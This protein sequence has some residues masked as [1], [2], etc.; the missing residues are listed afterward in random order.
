MTLH[1][2]YGS[3]MSR[4][5]MEPR[6]PGVTA[7]GTAVLHGFGFIIGRGGYASLEPRP[8]SVV[9]GVLW[10]LSARD[11]AAIDAYEGG[12]YLRRTLPVRRAGNLIPALVYI[13]ARP[14]R[15]KPRPA[16]IRL[17][18]EAAREWNLPQAYVGSLERWSPASL[19]GA[20]AKEAGEIG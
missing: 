3:N 16:Y 13:M 8:G 12:L 7:L 9:H 6:C 1:F 11:L 14:G 17:V 5:L 19:A 10:R 4:A 20:R 2:A 18:V 15:G